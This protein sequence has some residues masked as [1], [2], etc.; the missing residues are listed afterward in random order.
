MNWGYKLALGCVALL[1]GA[2]TAWLVRWWCGIPIAA[3]ILMF[4][5]MIELAD[6]AREE[7]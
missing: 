6:E 1:A 4:G 7:K 2:L 3:Y 5:Y